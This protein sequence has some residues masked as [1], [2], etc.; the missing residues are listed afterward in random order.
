MSDDE[1]QGFIVRG[2]PAEM[3]PVM[4]EIAGRSM[5]RIRYILDEGF[6]PRDAF[7]QIENFFKTE[8]MKLTPEQ[9]TIWLSNVL[10]K[11]IVEGVRNMMLQKKLSKAISEALGGQCDCDECRKKREQGGGKGCASDE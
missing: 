9:Q 3:L 2:W 7:D 5:K 10:A 6:G 1:K 4:E 11:N 8:L